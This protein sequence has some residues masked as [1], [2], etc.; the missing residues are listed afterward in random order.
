MQASYPTTISEEL[1]AAEPVRVSDG[2]T[3]RW[4]RKVHDGKWLGLTL[5][6]S[7]IVHSL[8]VGISMLYEPP[9]VEA[10]QPL[11]TRP[12]Q[13][14]EVTIPAALFAEITGEPQSQGESESA[15]ASDSQAEAPAPPA[16]AEQQK[17][18]PPAPAEEPVEQPSTV[19]ASQQQAEEPAPTPD[20]EHEE[21]ESPV[22]PD[23]DTTAVETSERPPTPEEPE[24]NEPEE[25][26]V[27]E[28]TVTDA[29]ESST[30]D[31][32]SSSG[33]ET[34]SESTNEG[35]T[36]SSAG[37]ERGTASASA[38][39][40]EE[41]GSGSA[42][43][44]S[45]VNRGLLDAHRRRLSRAMRGEN[46]CPRTAIRQRLNGVA[47]VGIRQNAR[48]NV[49]SVIL[50]RSAGHDVLDQEAV[51]FAENLHRMPAPPEAIRGSEF[52]VP[53]VFRCD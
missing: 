23:E 9:K 30:P 8:L 50:K 21:L 28:A 29:A 42:S 32:P 52:I 37:S 17:P 14:E 15:V 19:A 34:R 6:L 22:P 12:A 51:K 47:Y 11:D 10:A 35:N 16:Q 4:R 44:D 27:A 1:S 13:I 25:T 18:E 40:N 41:A 26:L 46:N 20:I 33:E 49:T 53:V 45:S 31:E 39:G 5:L 24:Q 38:R 43:G 7:L 48:G 2:A 36:G 3:A